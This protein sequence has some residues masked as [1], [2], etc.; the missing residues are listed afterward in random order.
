MQEGVWPGLPP[1]IL[2][3]KG[4]GVGK[5]LFRQSTISGVCRGLSSVLNAWY[6]WLI[7]DLQEEPLGSEH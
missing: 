6:E 7:L 2:S 4:R 5:G 3:A 1:A